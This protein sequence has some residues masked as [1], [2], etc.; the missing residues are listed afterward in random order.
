MRVASIETGGRTT[1]GV[2][3]PSGFCEAD[4]GLRESCP[5]LKSLLGAGLL[6]SL[7]GRLAGDLLPLDEVRFLP[8]I[9]NP[10]KI[11][12]VGVNYRPHVEEMGRDVPEY[13]VVFIRFANSLVGHREPVLRPRISDHY[14]FEG[15]LAIVIG[16]RARYVKAADA[17]D[18]IAGFCPFLD[19]SVRDWQRHTMQ[20]TAG[21]NFPRSGALGPALVTPDAIGD[22]A[23]VE[24]TTTV[25]GELMQRGRVS[26]LIFGVPELIEYCSA[27]AELEPGDLIA[28][29][30]PGGVGAAQKPP[31][32]LEPGDTISVDLGAIGRL[33]NVVEDEGVRG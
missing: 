16:K 32:W 25:S 13:P 6:E 14:D 1:Y 33:E 7:P 29:G 9:P 28:T 4:S 15:E 2:L 11:L 30:T 20:F 18:V 17:F 22:L 26:D 31:R 8:V 27:F 5:D 10:D 3:T 19:G 21:K 23:A 12:C 24:L